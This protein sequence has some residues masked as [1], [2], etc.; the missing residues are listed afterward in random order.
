MSEEH[1]SYAMRNEE[2]TQSFIYF[3]AP[4]ELLDWSFIVIELIL[5][6]GII[7]A[8]LH[9][10]RHARETGGN[11]ALLTLAAAPDT[12]NT[13]AA[14]HWSCRMERWSLTASYRK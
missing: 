14:P 11:G 8:I 13:W 1:I 5:V 12:P 10:I 6:T 2:A 4:G 7:C 3:N 9:A